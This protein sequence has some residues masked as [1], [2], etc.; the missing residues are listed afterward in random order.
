M[1]D[2][3]FTYTTHL[4]LFGKYRD[5]Y[6]PKLRLF[7]KLPWN[8]QDELVKQWTCFPQVSWMKSSWSNDEYPL[9]LRKKNNYGK[10]S[11]C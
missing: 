2:A 5:Q 6:I 10:S 7:S 3:I 11:I 9:P 8:S 1:F 4:G